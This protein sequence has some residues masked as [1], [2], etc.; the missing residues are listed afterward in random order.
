MANI[1][2]RAS[3]TPTVP[4]STISKGSPLTNLEVD[5]NFKSINDDILL[6]APLASPTLTGTPAAPTATAGTNT[7]QLATTAHVFAE[8]TNTATLT[9]KTLTTPVITN[10]T[11]TEVTL[12]DGATVNWDLDTGHTAKW[13]ITATGR[14][15]NT[16]TNPKVGGQYVLYVNL[17][18]PAT[19][20][21]TW[22]A[23]IVWPYGTAPDLTTSSNTLIS[24]VWSS[25]LSKF[26]GSYTP[27][28]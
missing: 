15:L 27:G 10:P 4:G 2:F 17:V 6:R 8:R 16:P 7:T 20:S 19:M 25:T 28:Y 13:A 26:L 3:T 22:S 1:T 5:G 14:T 21:P 12:V 9:N 11:N 23:N 18:T 24:L